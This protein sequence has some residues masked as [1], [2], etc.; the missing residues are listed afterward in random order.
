MGAK[1]VEGL[2]AAHKLNGQQT[3]GHSVGSKG[4]TTTIRCSLDHAVSGVLV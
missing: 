2:L 4:T 1:T 3:L